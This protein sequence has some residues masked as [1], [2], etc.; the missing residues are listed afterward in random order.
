MNSFS[1]P[2]SP[3]SNKLTLVEP[4]LDVFRITPPSGPSLQ[5]RLLARRC[6]N[7]CPCPARPSCI[8]AYCSCVSIACFAVFMLVCVVGRAIERSS[9]EKVPDTDNLYDTKRVCGRINV[10]EATYPNMTTYQQQSSDPPVHCGDC[11]YCSNTNDVRIYRETKNTLTK[12]ATHC[13][14]HVFYGGRESVRQCFH[15][16]VGF[17]DGCNECW[18]EN[19]LCNRNDCQFTCL[20]SIMSGE[21]NNRDS[22]EL[23]PCLLCDERMC[24]PDF[25]RCAGANRR[26]AGVESD[27][28]REAAEVCV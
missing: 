21:N 9:W 10:T 18:T 26:R 25:L 12:T 5:S 17:T 4:E 23:N 28:K 27:I 7:I 22:G 2:L 6:R 24:G 15:D 3:D 1:S 16:E 11:G 13:A 20:L 8:C 19:V 14:L